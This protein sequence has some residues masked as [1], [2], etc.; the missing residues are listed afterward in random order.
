[1]YVIFVSVK[2]CICM[3]RKCW[4]DAIIKELFYKWQKLVYSFPS[5][6]DERTGWDNECLG[7]WCYEQREFLWW[8]WGRSFIAIVRDLNVPV[9][10]AYASSHVTR[11][12]ERAQVIS[13][14]T[15]FSS[16]C[17]CFFVVIAAVATHQRCLYVLR[18]VALRITPS[19]VADLRL[20]LFSYWHRQF[21]HFNDYY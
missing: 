1:M 8:R 7:I 19:V 3:Q 20:T 13:R 5:A 16:S 17:R 4:D 15:Q 21:P 9:A 11:S 10:T 2:P 18:R 12:L 6:C 14:R